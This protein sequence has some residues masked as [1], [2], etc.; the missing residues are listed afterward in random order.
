M[1]SESSIES[2]SQGLEFLAEMEE[3]H[4]QVLED[5]N[6]L[7]N[8][9]EFVLEDFLKGNRPPADETVPAGE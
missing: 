2:N 8:K 3:R 7:N 5:L 9:I 1:D 6:S 4:N